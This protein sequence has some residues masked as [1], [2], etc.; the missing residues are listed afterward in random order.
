MTKNGS[1]Y[2]IVLKEKLELYMHLR[3]CDKFMGDG[4]P[5]QRSKLVSL[6]LQENQVKVLGWPGN[7]PDANLIE[8]L[9]KLI[10]DRAADKHPTCLKSI[11]NAIKIVWTKEISSDF[12]QT[13]N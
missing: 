3:Q 7:S 10:K 1:R 2:L 12:L 4:A 11:E 6:F 9:L 5:S 13:T 8:N